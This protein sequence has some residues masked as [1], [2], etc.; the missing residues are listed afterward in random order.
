MHSPTSPLPFQI[1]TVT[2]AVH[3]EGVAPLSMILLNSRV[4]TSAPQCPCSFH[5]SAGMSS[6]PGVFPFSSFS[7]FKI[8]ICHIHDYI[9]NI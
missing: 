9:E 7:R 2:L 3:A 5:A 8:F 1:G 6:G 4:R